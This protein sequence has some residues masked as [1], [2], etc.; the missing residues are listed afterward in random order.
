MIMVTNSKQNGMRAFSAALPGFA[1]GAEHWTQ[2]EVRWAR[3][4]RG[5]G[6]S[7]TLWH[8]WLLAA[9][10][11]AAPSWLMG[12]SENKENFASASQV[13]APTRSPSR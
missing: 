2:Q 7:G 6:H 9:S 3:H 1:R 5:S 8:C 10:L 13:L 11:I 4:T 12:T